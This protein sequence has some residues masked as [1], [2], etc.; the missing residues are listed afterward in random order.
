M[1]NM[2]RLFESDETSFDHNQYIMNMA[3]GYIEEQINDHYDIYL[4]SPIEENGISDVIRSGCFITVPSYDDRPDQIF[5]VRT[6]SP[7]VSTGTMDIYA[8]HILFSELDGNVILDSYVQNKSRKN[9]ISQLL[10]STLNNHK[11]KLGNL[12]NNT[13]INNLRV[14]RQSVIDALVGEDD[15]TIASRYG[16]EIIPNNYNINFCD[17]RGSDNSIVITHKVN[18]TGA[19]IT[20]DDLDQATEII[21][22]GKNGLMLPE[23]SIKSSRFDANHPLTRFK[24]YDIGVVEEELDDDGNVTNSDEVVTEEEAIKQLREAVKKD[25]S[26]NYLD[27]PQFSL[28]L[29]FVELADVV[30]LY[31]NDYSELLNSRVCIGDTITVN[32][33]SLGVS[34]VKGRIM[35]LKRNVNTGRLEEADIGYI[36]S[37]IYGTVNSHSNKIKVVKEDLS[38]LS[39]SIGKTNKK[40]TVKFGEVDEK[41]Q[42]TVQEDELGG[43]IEAAVDHILLA[44]N[45][46]SGETG[47]EIT[48]E[49]G[50][51]IKDGRLQLFTGSN[52]RVFWVS[53][54]GD[55][56]LNDT[57][58]ALFIDDTILQKGS[59]QFNTPN[60]IVAEMSAYK[61]GINFD[62]PIY[63]NH[64]EVDFTFK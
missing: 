60:D 16:G 50:V 39:D 51:V 17:Q 23:V 54:L 44:V 18:L 61:E 6:V 22:V 49:N 40:V 7:D 9:A 47:L 10:S 34:Q 3:D 53:G 42:A 15:N 4:T 33:A 20:W 46:A 31:G 30:D 14:V 62:C 8:Q 38:E 19:K 24:D 11:F 36:K 43:L 48:R 63:I 27:Q 55:I 32:I 28:S 2:V 58:G 29:N 21:P 37:T 56:H 64:K 25:F 57:D 26:N 41:F 59:L 52:K 5:R 45:N 12:D 1:Y 13:A 35:R